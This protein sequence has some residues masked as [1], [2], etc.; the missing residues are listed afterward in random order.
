MLKVTFRLGGSI[1]EFHIHPGDEE[2]LYRLRSRV[3]SIYTSFKSE[4]PKAV[5]LEASGPSAVWVQ[6]NFGCGNVTI[7]FPV[8]YWRGEG[9]VGEL[10]GEKQ[11]QSF[12]WSGDI[13]LTI[14]LNL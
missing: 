1:E 12:F 4:I 9:E 14:L 10:F 5:M 13:A 7:P 2:N 8:H 3:K 6:E 11:R